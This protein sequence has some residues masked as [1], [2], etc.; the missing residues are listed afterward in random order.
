M[1]LE[2]LQ[3]NIPLLWQLNNHKHIVSIPEL[4]RCH[5]IILVNLT[6]FTNRFSDYEES[7]I[8]Y[9]MTLVLRPAY[10][11]GSILKL[12]FGIF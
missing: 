12:G 9:W 6:K 7:L 2:V 5:T 8:L 1:H 10:T 3:R 11:I 4:L